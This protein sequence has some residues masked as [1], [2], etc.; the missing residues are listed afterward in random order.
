MVMGVRWDVN[1]A[2]VETPRPRNTWLAARPPRRNA[3]APRQ[4]GAED[5][6]TTA[7]RKYLSREFREFCGRDGI[8][9]STGRTGSSHDKAVAE[10]LGELVSRV[11]FATRADARRAIIA[12]IKHYNVVRLH[13][14]LGNVAP[15]EW[16]LR[17]AR[18][19][20]QAA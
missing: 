15:I 19:R 10:S 8:A 12:W 20:L 13:S 1:P 11:R 18:Q 7:A 2:S 16:E 3:R 17:F 5:I 9:Q 14:T 6:T 4:L